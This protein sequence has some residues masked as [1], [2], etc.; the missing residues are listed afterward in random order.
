MPVLSIDELQ[1]ASTGVFRLAGVPSDQVEIVVDLLIRANLAGHDSHG[2]VRIP[3]YVASV[4]SGRIKPELE[5]LLQDETSTSV[6]VEGQ[7]NFGQVVLSRAADIAIDKSSNSP[8]CLVTAMGYSH[9]GQLGAYAAKLSDSNRVGI[10]LLG[11]QKGSVVP[12]GGST[13]RI[14]QN[15][16]A[17]S[18]PS[19]QP[20]PVVLDMA[21]SVAPFG[22]VLMKRARNEPCPEGWLVDGD[23]N[24]SLDPFL[25]YNN[26]EG[27]FLPLGDPLVGHKGSGLAFV[28]GILAS[29]LSGAADREGTLL[30]AVNPGF[31]SPI[32]E[33]KQQV[34]D[35]VAYIQ[36]TPPLP[37]VDSVMA[38]GERSYRETQRRKIEGVFVEDETWGKIQNLV[39]G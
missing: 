35:Y 15:T 39:S 16:L 26:G 1:D 24:P 38:P 6:R 19:N 7:G 22:K 18:I 23:G 5:I 17:V 32:E 27:G 4:K 37:N 36:K 29:A 12:S 34:D 33:F 21:T 8:I 20:F 10:V 2:V 11:K 25:D 9:C 31:F 3:G 13:G 28:L 30:I 14:Y